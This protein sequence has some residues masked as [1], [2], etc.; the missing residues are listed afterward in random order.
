MAAWPRSF[1]SN[2]VVA[3]PAAAAETVIAQ[4]AVTTDGPSDIVLLQGWCSYTTG[5]ATTTVLAQFRRASVSGTI[6]GN[7]VPETIIGAVGA[8]HSYVETA[9]DQPGDV[10]SLLYVWTLTPANGTNPGTVNA[11]VVSALVQSN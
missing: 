1:R 8:V 6:V 11:V 10:T 3:S 4:V 9:V 2:V 5:T 7:T